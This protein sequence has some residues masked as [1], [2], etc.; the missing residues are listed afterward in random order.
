MKNIILTIIIGLLAG[1]GFQQYKANESL[2]IGNQSCTS[3]SGKYTLNFENYSHYNSLGF[4]QLRQY[5]QFEINASANELLFT[6][7]KNESVVNSSQ[8]LRPDWSCSK[9]ILAI[10]IKNETQNNGGVTVY[11]ARSLQ[12]YS[13]KAGEV[14]VRYKQ[15]STG[16]AFLI[17]VSTFDDSVVK[18]NALH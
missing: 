3:L 15:T 10:D 4:W 2:V 9:G 8:I 1:C 16:L 14:Y 11:E 6:G 5:D 18:L 7:Y 12:L 17:P 13:Y